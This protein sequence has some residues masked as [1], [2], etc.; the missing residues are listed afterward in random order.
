[1]FYPDYGPADGAPDIGDSAVLEL[2][3]LGSAAA[4]G[5]LA[6][7]GLLGGRTSD[8]ACPTGCCNSAASVG[9]G[10]TSA[11]EAD[12]PYRSTWTP[13]PGTER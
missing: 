12:V 7:A 10:Y 11:V 2:V 9:A 13:R 4:A 3:G 1:M 5:S 8:D 6:V